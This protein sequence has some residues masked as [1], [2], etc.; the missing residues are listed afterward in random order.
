[1]ACDAVLGDE[2]T[3]ATVVDQ[4]ILGGTTMSGFLARYDLLG[5]GDRPS[6]PP[7]GDLLDELD[8]A[9]LES[10]RAHDYQVGEARETDDQAVAYPFGERIIAE[11]MRSSRTWD[12]FSVRTEGSNALLVARLMADQPSRLEVRAGTDIAGAIELASNAEWNEAVVP[13]PAR[14]SAKTVA[15]SIASGPGSKFASAHYWVYRSATTEW[16]LDRTPCERGP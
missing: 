9:D 11:G 12:R 1:M 5:S 4:T 14:S 6:S 10:E 13:L 7:A 15:L 2:L 16:M 3:S 8:V